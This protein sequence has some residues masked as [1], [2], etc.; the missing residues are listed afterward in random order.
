MPTWLSSVSVRGG[1]P[2]GVARRCRGCRD[3]SRV[4]IAGVRNGFVRFTGRTS[5]ISLEITG[6]GI[7]EQGVSDLGGRRAGESRRGMIRVRPSRDPGPLL[8][9]RC[10]TVRCDSVPEEGSSGLLCRAGKFPMHA[11]LHRRTRCVSHV[12]HTAVN[13]YHGPPMCVAVKS[14]NP[15]GRPCGEYAHPELTVS[16]NPPP[17]TK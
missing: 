6:S 8:G 7:D 10:R 12:R 16:P 2:V 11:F 13:S 5:H 17:S 14:S 4:L 3:R 1:H 9:H 15:A